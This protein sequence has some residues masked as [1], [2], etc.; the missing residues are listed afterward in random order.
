MY[1]EPS[2]L[3]ADRS[4]KVKIGDGLVLKESWKCLVHRGGF[5]AVSHSGTCNQVG[6]MRLSA[7]RTESYASEMSA[8][9]TGQTTK[10]SRRTCI[11]KSI[12]LSTEIKTTP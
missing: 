1:L 10:N 8:L 12:L 11:S 3:P 4:L 7:R 2:W 5:F 9:N 6:V